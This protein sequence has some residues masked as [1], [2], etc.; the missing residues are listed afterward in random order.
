MN[1]FL[2]YLQ[3]NDTAESMRDGLDASIHRALLHAKVAKIVKLQLLIVS[4]VN[5]MNDVSLFYLQVRYALTLY[6]I[7]IIL[8]HLLILV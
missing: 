4:M 2:L 8:C 6:V 1:P 3:Y 5:N 7:T